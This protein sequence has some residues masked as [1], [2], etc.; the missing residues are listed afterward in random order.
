MPSRPSAF[1]PF[2]PSFPLPD[3]HTCCSLLLLLVPYLFV[4]LSDALPRHL[5]PRWVCWP[6]QPNPLLAR[7]VSCQDIP[8]HPR[9]RYSFPL[10]PAPIPPS[11]ICATLTVSRSRRLAYPRSPTPSCVLI[12][13]TASPSSPYAAANLRTVSPSLPVLS[14]PPPRHTTAALHDNCL[15]YTSDAADE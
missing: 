14:H 2:Y 3:P 5:H 12:V 6:G 10:L 7:Y 4:R 1:R 13:D 9:L 15:L 11:S 8:R